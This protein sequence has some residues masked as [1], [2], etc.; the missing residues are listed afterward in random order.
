MENPKFTILHII[1]VIALATGLLPGCAPTYVPNVVNTPMLTN[2]GEFHANLNTGTAGFDPQLSYAITDNIGVM[3]NGSLEN[4]HR[5]STDSHHRHKFVE[6]GAGYFTKFSGLGRFETYVGYGRGTINAHYDFIFWESFSDV[7]YNRI[8]VQPAIGIS[9]RWFD[10]SFAL[11]MAYVDIFQL[12]H[13]TDGFFME[14]TVTV[15]L[16]YDYFKIV[17]Q[18]GYSFPADNY[19]RFDYE[20]FMFSV[21]VQVTLGRKVNSK[22]KKSKGESE[23]KQFYNL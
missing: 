18:M 23:F 11:R 4:R 6:F 15:K 12:N 19:V 13:R 16:G 2:K 22:E 1:A 9:T 14:P 7:K 5:D 21:G 20:P 17:S 3:L 10:G 8:F